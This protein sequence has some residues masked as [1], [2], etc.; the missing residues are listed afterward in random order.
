MRTT[1]KPCL[2]NTDALML[3]HKNS[4]LD[5]MVNV[6]LGKFLFNLLNRKFYGLLL[7]RAYDKA[8]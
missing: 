3:E 5:T 1:T 2:P 7:W 8:I 4:F 6:V